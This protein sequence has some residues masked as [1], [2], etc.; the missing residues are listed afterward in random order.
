MSVDPYVSWTD[1]ELAALE[2]GLRSDLYSGRVALVT[3]G[4]GGIGRAICMLLGRLGAR[5]ITCGRDES[6]L[7]E[8]EKSLGGHGIDICSIPMT[9]RDPDQVTELIDAAWSE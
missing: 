4:A 9:I 5:I 3:G 2:H 6:K 7:L 1:D 8:L